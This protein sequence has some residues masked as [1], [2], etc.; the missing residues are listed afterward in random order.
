MAADVKLPR[1]VRL[2]FLLP[3][4]AAA[5]VLL[6]GVIFIRHG[7]P[8]TVP[9]VSHELVHCQQL[10]DLGLLRYWA[11]YV[12][13]WVRSGFSWHRHPMERDAEDRAHLFEGAARDVIEA[14]GG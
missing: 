10:A 2:P 4:S 5:Q 14:A 11:A 7:T 13:L 1:I 8:L 3:P 6:P 12:W 9:L